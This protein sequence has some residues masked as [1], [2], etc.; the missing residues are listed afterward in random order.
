MPVRGITNIFIQSTLSSLPLKHFDGVY[1]M[2][3]LKLPLPK[4]DFAL[5]VN[6][7]NKDEEGKHFVVLAQIGN[8]LILFDFLATPFIFLPTHLQTIMSTYNGMFFFK[9]PIQ[10]E[11][12]E[13]CGF[14]TMYFILYINLLSKYKRLQ[15]SPVQFSVVQLKRNDELCIDLIA[16]GMKSLIRK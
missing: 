7:S 5:V 4:E 15:L 12:S 8:C 9:Y 1:S 2:D 3:E 10:D 13:Y 11:T 6:F 16:R 14:Y